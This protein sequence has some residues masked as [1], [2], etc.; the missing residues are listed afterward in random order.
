MTISQSETVSKGGVKRFV[1]G[2][3]VI[4]GLY[5]AVAE[6]TSQAMLEAAWEVGV[7]SF[8]TAPHYGA[9]LSE[10]RLG[11]FL[12]EF[13]RDSFQLSTKVGR[14]LVPTDTDVEGREGFFGGDSFDRVRDYS[15]EGVRRSLEESLERLGL[16]RIDTALIHDPEDY[17]DWAIGEACPAL[18]SLRSQGVIASVG[19]GM[20]LS[21]ELTRLVRET[22][23]DT[24]MLAGRYT[25]LDRSAEFDVLPACVDRGVSVMAAGVFNSGILADPK[26]GAHFDYQTA[27]E[28]TVLAA[29]HLK[30]LCA[31][32]GVPLRAA[33]AQFPLRHPAVVTVCVGART[34][35]QVRE[36]VAMLD[37]FIPPEL[38]AAIDD[39]AQNFI[40]QST[41]TG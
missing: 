1:L 8:D 17:M 14:L 11:A 18:L 35:Q 20:N 7:R 27:G 32:Y 37:V 2:C 19:A 12:R 24:V 5:R 41:S 29:L 28:H 39:V 38:W 10:R 26:H 6:A 21:A 33:A 23:V 40:E 15:A 3:A 4:G 31:A 34:A 30:E 25:L 22:D 16:D 9:G 36:N 13:P